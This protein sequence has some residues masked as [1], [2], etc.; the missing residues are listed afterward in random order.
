MEEVNDDELLEFVKRLSL[1][2][3]HVDDRKHKFVSLFSGMG[4]DCLGMSQAGCQS[5]AFNE[6]QET[7]C[8]THHVNDNTSTLVREQ[9]SRSICDLEDTT[10]LE[11]KGRFDI[12]FAGFCCQ[13]FSVG[14]AR[15]NDDVRDKLYLEFVRFARLTKP[16]L[17]IGENV[18][19][20]VSK[21]TIEGKKYCELLA[22]D[23]N[24]LAMM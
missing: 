18:K 12:L 4:G 7:F 20:F 3:T 17:I 1:E 23:L 15:R 14:G 24:A 6:L 11:Y 5:L 8:Q 16:S 13:S 2:T 21:T 22:E 10:I 19:G 9:N